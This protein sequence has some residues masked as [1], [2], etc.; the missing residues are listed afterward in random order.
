MPRRIDRGI[1]DFRPPQ[2][3]LA[4]FF[5]GGIA[6][7]LLIVTVKVI[8]DS[9]NQNIDKLKRLLHFGI[10]EFQFAIWPIRPIIV[11]EHPRS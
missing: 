8:G 1:G 5:F 7:R 11:F 6:V 9:A 4:E 2:N 10:V 3:M